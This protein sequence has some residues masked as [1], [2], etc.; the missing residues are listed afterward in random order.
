MLRRPWRSQAIVNRPIVFITGWMLT[1]PQAAAQT[2]PLP[3]ERLT[4]LPRLAG[5]SPASPLWAPDSKRIA[6]LWNH[7]ALPFRDIWM[8]TLD[9]KPPQRVT[10]MARHFP[11]P[12]TADLPA[13]E[14]L[15]LEAAARHHAGIS[16]AVWTPDG[17][18]FVFAFRTAYDAPRVVSR[19]PTPS[20]T[21][22]LFRIGADGSDL[23]RLTSSPGDKYALGFSPDG[24]YLSF[25]QEGDLWLWHQQTKELV[26]VTRLARPPIGR[27]PLNTCCGP[28]HSRPDVEISSYLWSPDGRFL[29]L[30]IDD[31]SRVRKVLLPDYLGVETRAEPNRRDYPGDNDHARDLAL[32]SVEKGRVQ[33]VELPDTTDRSIASLAWSPDS[34]T[35]LVDQFPQSAVHRWIFAVSREDGSIR[36]LWHDERPTRTT[37]HWISTWS[38]AGDGIVFVSDIDGRHRLYSL[39]LGEKTPR[40]LTPGDWSVIGESGAPRVWVS[41]SR[42]EIF[43]VSNQKSP[44][45][46]HV[47]RMPEAG[48]PITQVTSMPGVHHPFPSPDGSQIALL[49]SN[50]ITPTELYVVGSEGGPERR[51]THSPAKDFADYAWVEPRYVTFPSHV[52]GTTLHGRILEPRGLD[53]SKKYPIILGP[54]YSNSVRNR[55]GDRDEWRGLYSSLQQYLTLEG[56]YIVFQVDVRGSVGYGREFREKLRRDYGGIDVEDL[57]SGARY[58]KTLPYVDPDRFGI[59]GSSYGGLMTAMSLFKK[60][61]L[62]KAGVASAPATNVWHA[63][64]GQVNVAGRPEANPE[65]YRKVSAVSYGEN[66]QDHLMIV[67]GM[68]DSIV[69]FK[70]SVTLAEKLM[71]LGKDFELVVAPSAVHEWGTKDYVGAYVLRKL[72]GHFDRYLGRGPR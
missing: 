31:R 65:T 70:D 51:L 6:F 4:A 39:K 10:D 24:K 58:L 40:L 46:R 15:A 21:D 68:Q 47:C 33:R 54:V 7:Q 64:T 41:R 34:R 62:Y 45:E 63:M 19:G 9:G 38:G 27:S 29:A 18:G 60:P 59:W 48:G 3:L 42:K 8:A 55:W 20:G 61:G 69:L 22:D 66:L 23:T 57:E 2:K 36:E 28:G 37:Q 72:V 5:T 13:D 1:A 35:L 53:R 12:A 26:Q 16:E 11:P 30:Q 49:Y 25:L 32:Y 14:K 67:H 50:D 43:F 17:H 56:Q 52:D 71:L 44:Y